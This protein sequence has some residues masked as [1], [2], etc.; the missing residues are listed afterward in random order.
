[1]SIIMTRRSPRRDASI[2]PSITRLGF[3]CFHLEG[4]LGDYA[5]VEVISLRGALRALAN[6]R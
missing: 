3:T 4:R 2:R 1:V 5:P 6:R